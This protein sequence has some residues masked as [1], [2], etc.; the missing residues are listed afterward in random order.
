MVRRTVV[1]PMFPTEEQKAILLE[2]IDLYSQSWNYCIDV[3]WD[4]D[5]LTKTELHE[6]TYVILKNKLK[7]KS[8]YLCSSRDR[9]IET[10]RAMRALVARGKKI[11][12]PSYKTIPI[13]LDSRTLSF[14]KE[15]SVASITTQKSRVKIPLIWHKQAMRYKVWLCKAGEIGVNRDGKFVLRLIF[16]MA[17]VMPQRSKNIFGADRGIKR[18]IVLSNN[19]FYGESWWKEHERKLLSLVSRLQSK[20]TKSARSHAK[21]VWRRLRRFREDCDRV[22]AKEIILFLHPGDTIVLEILI[23]IRDKCGAKGKSHK[24]HRAKVNCWSFKRLE[25]AI[26]YNAELSGIYVEQVDAHYTS[27]MCSRC[28]VV[29]KK[30]RKTQALYS[31]ECGLNLNADLNAARN[32]ANKW[33]IASGHTSGLPVDQPIVTDQSFPPVTSL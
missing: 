18:P 5:R 32:I 14:D 17:P 25:Q 1:F 29:C 19:K 9:A 31:C 20:G 23:N 26:K 27:Q 24:K 13:R 10:V 33:C 15:R 4:M 22:I 28:N 12:K 6:S 30:N 3:A 8:Q 21:K 16:E 11:S 7:L 2:T